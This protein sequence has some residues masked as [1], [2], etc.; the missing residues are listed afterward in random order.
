MLIQRQDHVVAFLNGI[1][2]RSVEMTD[3]SCKF[4]VPCVMVPSVSDDAPANTASNKA[5]QASLRELETAKI[6]VRRDL[7]GTVLYGEYDFAGEM[8]ETVCS[9]LD[10]LA[11]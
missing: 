7:S 8:R 5:L 9:L 3:G 6:I 10:N 2:S 4:Y 11:E 1:L